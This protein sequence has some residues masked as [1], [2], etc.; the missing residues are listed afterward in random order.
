MLLLG[1]SVLCSKTYEV[2]LTKEDVNG[3]AAGRWA[4][5]V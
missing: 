5:F 4:V 1:M 3:D 2:R